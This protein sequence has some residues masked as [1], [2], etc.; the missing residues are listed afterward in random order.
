VTT[1][2]A[3][4]GSGFAVVAFD[5]MVTEGEDKKYLLPRDI[6]KVVRTKNCLL[7]AAG[8]LRA[9]NLLS[10]LDLPE[11]PNNF[12]GKDLDV[13]VAKTFVPELK[14]M[15]HEAG[16][17]K[18]NEQPSTILLVANSTVFE[19]GS[20]YDWMRDSRGI[21]AMGTGGGYAL[22]YLYSVGDPSRLTLAAAKDAVIQAVKVAVEFDP[23]TSEPVYA[24][25]HK[26]Q[27]RRK[28]I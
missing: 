12:F 28:K 15:F 27:Q 8:D 4:Q 24:E 7:G 25:I 6:P 16:Y 1:I 11:P 13:W 5:S 26:R 20:N 14:S 3:L 21:Y 9:V 23:C 10:N 22:G 18:D 19:I 17:E 2:A